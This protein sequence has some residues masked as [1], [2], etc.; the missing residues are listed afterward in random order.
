MMA[1]T[2]VKAHF[3]ID[4]AAVEVRLEFRVLKRGTC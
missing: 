2:T 1:A 3:S 4:G